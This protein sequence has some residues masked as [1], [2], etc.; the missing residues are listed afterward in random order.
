MD[1]RIK[2]WMLVSVALFLAEIGRL[3]GGH[4]HV[5]LGEWITDSLA[6]VLLLIMAIR[7]LVERFHR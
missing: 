5:E 7:F 3:L 4:F 1:R 6:L 2:N